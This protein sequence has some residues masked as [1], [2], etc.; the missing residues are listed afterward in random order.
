MWPCLFFQAVVS[1]PRKRRTL[2]WA[3]YLSARRCIVLT[4]SAREEGHQI[5]LLPLLCQL[6]Q[7]ACR[8]CLQEGRTH[9]LLDGC[10]GLL[11]LGG[12]IG[13]MQKNEFLVAKKTSPFG[14]KIGLE[15]IRHES[16]RAHIR[17]GRSHDL[18]EPFGCLPGHI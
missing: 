7:Y 10:S 9:A 13:G 8:A 6:P 11:D 1:Q 2:P 18:Q 17:S 12:L 15:W 3:C 4:L 5:L 16:P 14:N